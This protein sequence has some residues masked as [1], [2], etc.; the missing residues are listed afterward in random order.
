V[1]HDGAD[2]QRLLQPPWVS[3][4]DDEAEIDHY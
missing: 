4:S 3:H 1:G 2:G